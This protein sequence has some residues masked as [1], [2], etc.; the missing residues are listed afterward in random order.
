MLYP[1]PRAPLTPIS[2][3]QQQNKAT[4]PVTMAYLPPRLNLRIVAVNPE[5]ALRDKGSVLVLISLTMAPIN[6]VSKTFLSLSANRRH[7]SMVAQHLVGRDLD[8][9]QITFRFVG[10]IEEAGDGRWSGFL[11]VCAKDGG[12]SNSTRSLGSGS[13]ERSKERHGA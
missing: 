12:H 8:V 3:D 4:Y 9:I 5:T 1:R 7:T 13:G 6:H 2:E 10:R 11:A